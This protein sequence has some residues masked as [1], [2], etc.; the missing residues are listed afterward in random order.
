MS[1]L[2]IPVTLTPA[3]VMQAALCGVMRQAKSMHGR[4]R[5]GYEGM[6][7]YDAWSRHIE[8]AAGECATAKV[9]GRYWPASLNTFDGPDLG[10]NIQ[11]RTRSRPEYELIVRPVARDADLYVLVTGRIPQFLVCGWLLAREAKRECWLRPHGARPPAYFVPQ[12]ALRDI[13]ELKTAGRTCSTG[14]KLGVPLAG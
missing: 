1:A 4:E 7:N 8:G 2:P 12:A 5:N 3:E 13:E 10:E 11:V 9:L 14:N 6:D